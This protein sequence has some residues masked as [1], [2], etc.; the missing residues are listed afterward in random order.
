MSKTTRI[1]TGD[2]TFHVDRSETSAPHTLTI[3]MLDRVEGIGGQF[4][5]TVSY[6]R[7]W[8][9]ESQGFYPATDTFVGSV[10]GGPVVL[11]F[12]SGYQYRIDRSVERFGD[13]LSRRWLER[14][15]ELPEGTLNG[16]GLHT[17]HSGEIRS[18]KD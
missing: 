11:V 5:F 7:R 14:W 16:D 4:R 1:V 15:F 6:T 8:D 2:I 17:D 12:P 13:T 18:G 10:Y 9:D 3:H